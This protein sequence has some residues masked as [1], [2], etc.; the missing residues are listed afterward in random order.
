MG[1]VTSEKDWGTVDID[2][3]TGVILVRE[4][5]H[6]TWHTDPGV[7]PFSLVQKRAFHHRLDREIWGKW[8]WYFHVHVR[9]N[10]PFA[11]RFAERT[12]VINFDIR[13]MLHPAQWE[14]EV[15]RV[16]RGARM[17]NRTRSNV[18]FETRNIQLFSLLFTPYTAQADNGAIRP[19]FRAGPH[20]FGHTLNYPDD[21]K[22]NSPFRGDIDSIMNIGQQLRNRHIA[23]VV[24]TLNTMIPGVHFET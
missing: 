3:E 20:E 15:I 11:H 1:H 18:T 24:D 12:L 8:S 14:V 10:T 6:Y 5:W 4:D 22:P 16:A 2:T 13:W 21:Y 7:A 9:G 19:G 23:L 17:N